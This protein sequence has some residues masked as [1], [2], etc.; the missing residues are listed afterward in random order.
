MMLSKPFTRGAAMNIRTIRLMLI[1]SLGIAVASASPG[2]AQT[3]L[4]GAK[5]QQNKIG[6]VAKPAP[7]IGGAVIHTPPPPNPPKPGPVANTVKPT[8]PGATTPGLSSNAALN[9]PPG[10]KPNPPVTP[11]NKGGAVVTSNLNCANGACTSKGP[12]P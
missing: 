11:P 7:A 6:G 9:Q 10:P 4:G 2:L 5:T 12:K 8:S 1:G 3:T